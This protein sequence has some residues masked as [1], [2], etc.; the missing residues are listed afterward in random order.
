MTARAYEQIG[1]TRSFASFANATA[2]ST[3]WRPRPVPRSDVEDRAMGEARDAAWQRAS[4]V[5]ANIKENVSAKV[6]D[7][8]ENFVDTN[9][10][11]TKGP[12]SEPVGHA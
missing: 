8:A 7:A 4:K 2:F 5:A 10:L 12:T 3:S 9:I 1:R 11:G 6:A